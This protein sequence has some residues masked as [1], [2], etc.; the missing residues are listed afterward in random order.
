MLNATRGFKTACRDSWTQL[1]IKGWPNPKTEYK[2]EKV[3]ILQSKIELLELTFEIEKRTPPDMEIQVN[4]TIT[5]VNGGN[6]KWNGN[7]SLRIQSLPGSRFIF[8]CQ[9]FFDKTKPY[10]EYKLDLFSECRSEK[11]PGYKT[12]EYLTDRTIKDINDLPELVG[13]FVCGI[14]MKSAIIQMPKGFALAKILFLLNTEILHLDLHD[15]GENPTEEQQESIGRALVSNLSIR[16]LQ[17]SHH[18][19]H[20]MPLVFEREFLYIKTLIISSRGGPYFIYDKAFSFILN[21]PNL[22]TLKIHEATKVFERVDVLVDILHQLERLQNLKLTFDERSSKLQ[23]KDLKVLV[24][25]IVKLNR[26]DFSLTLHVSVIDVHLCKIT[27]PLL[28]TANIKR[29]NIRDVKSITFGMGDDSTTFKSP[30]HC[31]KLNHVTVI[32]RQFIKSIRTRCLVANDSNI[33]SN[34]PV[35]LYLATTRNIATFDVKRET[36][37]MCEHAWD[38]LQKYKNAVYMSSIN[39]TVCILA[40]RRFRDSELSRMPKE[41]VAVI[42]RYVYESYADPVWSLQD[43][44]AI[45]KSDEHKRIS[46]SD[47]A[48]E[49]GSG[50]GFVSIWD[51]PEPEL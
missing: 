35:M 21:F 50:K 11:T 14:P 33:H 36:K 28:T 7:P 15:V 43:R 20:Q 49:T 9:F 18:V 22:K 13:G 16:T 27:E 25:G 17:L 23:A 46:C 19:V 29:L 34:Y 4:L 31:L 51:S 44:P 45:Y 2:P 42:A 38:S 37:L 30:S 24:D 41:I 48:I 6:V 12:C 8:S 32:S 1:A 47:C 10:P 39:A 3:Y 40:I 26:P 5:D